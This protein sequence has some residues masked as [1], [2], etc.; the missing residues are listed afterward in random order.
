MTF[1]PVYTDWG[2]SLD[3]IEPITVMVIDKDSP[4][5]FVQCTRSSLARA[6][7]SWTRK[8]TYRGPKHRGMGMR[9]FLSNLSLRSTDSLWLYLCYLQ[10]IMNSTSGYKAYSSPEFKSCL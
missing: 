10:L 3:A 4:M 9:R 6:S 2:S 7:Q 5:V 1:D 8:N